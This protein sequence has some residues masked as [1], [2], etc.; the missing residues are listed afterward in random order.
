MS[1]YFTTVSNKTSKEI[2]DKP[3]KLSPKEQ[4]DLN[5]RVFGK[6]L[7]SVKERIDDGKQKGKE[8]KKRKSSKNR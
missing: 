4:K 8:S 5:R 6:Q 2:R 3:K 7:K 1:D